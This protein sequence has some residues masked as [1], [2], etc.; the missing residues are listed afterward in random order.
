MN[1]ILESCCEFIN[2]P[3]YVYTVAQKNWIVILQKTE[4]TINNENRDTVKDV[5]HATYKG[6]YFNVKK[7]FNKI[8]HESIDKINEITYYDKITYIVNKEISTELPFIIKYYKVIHRAYYLY[9]I[10]SYTGT[11][12]YWHNNGYFM[13]YVDF[14]NGIKNGVYIRW[15]TNGNTYTEGTFLNGEKH[16]LWTVYHNNGSIASKGQYIN[17]RRNGEWLFYDRNGNEKQKTKLLENDIPNDNIII[18]DDEWDFL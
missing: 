4:N 17:G 18:Q 5:R 6:N 9:S 10:P 14:I 16:G 8:T 1:K 3:Q 2:D 11:R 12:I 7:I 15:Y 13:A